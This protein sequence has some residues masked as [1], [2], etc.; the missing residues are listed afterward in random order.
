MLHFQ[1]LMSLTNF[2]QLEK[3]GDGAYSEVFKARRRKDGKIY[4]LKKCKIGRLKPKEKQNSLNEIRILASVRSD[5]IVCYKEAFFDDV[6]GFLCLIMEYA[7]GGDLYQKIVSCTKTSRY[8]EEAFIWKM[9]YE[10]VKGLKVL[11][12]LK[13]FHRDIKSANIFLYKDGSLKLGD[14]N[15]S[16]VAKKGMLVT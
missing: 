3:I 5:Y 12:D 6:T 14:L 16:K 9:I 15:V 1:N 11:H 10:V 2:E 4:A 8:V 13:I 7:D